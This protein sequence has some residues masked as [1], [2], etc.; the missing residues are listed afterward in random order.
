[1]DALQEWVSSLFGS[2]EAIVR[3]VLAGFVIIVIGILLI[4][5]AKEFNSGNPR[6]SLKHL[7]YAL[8]VALIGYM[9]I[10]GLQ[11]F[12][13]NIKPDESIIP[14]DNLSFMIYH[15]KSSLPF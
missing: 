11:K 4:K 12:M 8:A 6:D 5:A 1:M 2:G 13:E 14:A 15:I 9:G 10:G 3:T 7:G